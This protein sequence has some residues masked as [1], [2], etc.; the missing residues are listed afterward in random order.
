MIRLDFQFL[1]ILVCILKQTEFLVPRLT[2]K[3]TFIKKKYIISE[4][5]LPSLIFFHLL[6]SAFF[7]AQASKV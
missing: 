5:K 7:G 4:M 2:A 3:V 1:S 6:Y